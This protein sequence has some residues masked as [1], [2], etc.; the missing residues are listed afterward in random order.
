V[1]KLVVYGI[2]RGHRFRDRG[3]GCIPPVLV[4]W[5]VLSTFRCRICRRWWRFTACCQ[6]PSFWDRGALFWNL[7]YFFTGC[8]PGYVGLLLQLVV[9]YEMV[10]KKYLHREMHL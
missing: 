7:H 3:R 10:G 4:M 9:G 5:T 1:L 8:F 6:F 2:G